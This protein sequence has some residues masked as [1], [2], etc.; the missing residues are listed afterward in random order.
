MSVLH[1]N[2]SAQL[3]QTTTCIIEPYLV[4]P[5]GEQVIARSKQQADVLMS[6]FSINE[7]SG[8]A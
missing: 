4:D 7:F 5:L 1:I 6:A 2:I 3:S 8:A